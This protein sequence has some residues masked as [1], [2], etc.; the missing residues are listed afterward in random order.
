MKTRQYTMPEGKTE[1]WAICD[2]PADGCGGGRRR[3]VLTKQMTCAFCGSQMR[4]AARQS[5]M[6]KPA[7]T[8]TQ[9]QALASIAKATDAVPPLCYAIC[10]TKERR[11]KDVQSLCAAGLI[12]EFDSGLAFARGVSTMVITDAGRATL[13]DEQLA[14]VEKTP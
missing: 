3:R 4:L 9:R 14:V 5:R 10:P 12:R 11:R 2:A 13:R 1:V 6:S 7:L 8:K